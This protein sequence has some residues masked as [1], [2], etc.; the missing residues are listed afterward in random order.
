MVCKFF[1]KKVRS[2]VTMLAN[3]SDVNSVPND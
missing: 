3:K 2:G 1:D